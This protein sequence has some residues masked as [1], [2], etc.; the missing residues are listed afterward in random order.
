MLLMCDFKE[1]TSRSLIT[2]RN[3]RGYGTPKNWMAVHHECLFYV[4]GRPEFHVQYTD[5]P[6]ILRGYYKEI[7]GRQTEN[8]GRSKSP[9]IRPGNVWVYIQQV[10]Y[11]MQ[12]NVSGCY[13]QKPLKA[14]ERILAAS[15]L[16]G[17][18]VLDFFGHS[19]TTADCS[20]KFK[21]TL[22]CCR[23]GSY[24]L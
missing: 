19:G 3:Q 1:F 22:L 4:K 10:F 16:E 14:I 13:A 17:G 23:Y 9:N 8:L 2:M 7:N 6:K 18:L 15:S 11:R 5:I 20:R 12:E 21:Q 24:L